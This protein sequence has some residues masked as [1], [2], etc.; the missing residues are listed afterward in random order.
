LE[1]EL[2]EISVIIGMNRRPVEPPSSGSFQNIE[3]FFGLIPR[4]GWRADHRFM[5][6]I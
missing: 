5:D 4:L 1:I 3:M 2:R 6:A